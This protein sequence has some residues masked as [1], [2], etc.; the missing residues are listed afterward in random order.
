MLKGEEVKGGIWD[1][2]VM[3][4]NGCLGIN[5]L[6]FSYHLFYGHTYNTTRVDSFEHVTTV[7]HCNVASNAVSIDW[8]CCM[9]IEPDA[10][11]SDIY[12]N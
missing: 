9:S 8:A 2:E 11:M 4:D 6:Y 12:S 7:E 3:V 10:F 5:G 1:D